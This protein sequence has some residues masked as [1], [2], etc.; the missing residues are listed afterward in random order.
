[1][2]FEKLNALGKK[3]IPFIFISNFELDKL[4][5]IPLSELDSHDIEYS[6]NEDFYSTRHTHQLKKFPMQY[7]E[8]KDK[9]DKVIEKIKSGETYLLNLTAHTAIQSDLNLQEIYSVVNAHYKIR[10]KDEFVCFSPEKF[11]QIKGNKISTFPMKGTIDAN[12]EDAENKIL[13]DKKEMAEHVMVVDLLR[14]DLS[15]VSKNVR[16][17]KFRY[18]TKIKAHKQEI[19]QVSSHI[20]GEL[21]DNWEETIGDIF[22][23]LLPCGSISDT[24]KKSTLEIIKKI[25]K[26]DRGFYSGIFGIY[27]GKTLDSGVLIRFIQNTTKGLVYKSGGGITLDSK[28]QKEYNEL[29]D[30]IYLP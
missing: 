19:L 13:N 3:K 6:I 8:Y 11:V 24:P 15:M 14:N 7:S 27:D 1:M 21:S 5:V 23:K 2:D 10:Y 30:K 29:L 25:E 4:V 16:V 22:K 18:I 28:P 17:E 26:Y 9:F 12:I 20:S